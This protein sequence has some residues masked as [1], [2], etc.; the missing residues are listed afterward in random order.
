MRKK[1]RYPAWWNI[2][3]IRQPLLL[4]RV[5]VPIGKD[6]T[7]DGN[8]NV[9]ATAAICLERLA[10]NLARSFDFF[11]V[12]A[13]CRDDFLATN[14]GICRAYYEREEISERVKEYI[15]PQ[16]AADSADVVF[17]DAEGKTVL[18]DDIYQDDEGYFVYHDQI[19]DVENEKICLEPVLYRD[20]Y[21]DPDI[22][23]WKRCKRL[24]FVEYYSKK[25]FIEI[26]GAEAFAQIPQPDPERSVETKAAPK[27]QNIKVY[28]YWDEYENDVLWFAEDG[29]DFIT[30]KGYFEPQN[31]E[32]YALDGEEPKRGLYD[33][34]KFFPVPDPLIMNAATD[35]FY[36][37]PE[38]Y[39]LIEVFEDI[40]MIFSRMMALTRAIRARVLFDNNVDGLQEAL[41]E[42]SEGDA[43]GVPNLAQSLT[44]AGGTLDAVVQYIPVEKLINGLNQ[45]YIALDQRLMSVQRLTGTSDLLQGMSGDQSGK[46]LGERQIEEKYATNQIYE[47]QR[48]MSAF[49][50]DSYQLICEMALKN[51]KDASL[52]MYIIPATLQPEHR[53]RYRAALGML[54]E[55][56]KRFRIELETDSTIALNEQYD[57]QMRIELVNALTTALEKTANIA[58]VSPALVVTELHCLKYLVQGFRQGKM[59]QTEITQS[60]DNVIRQAAQ[61]PAP[62]N[63]DETGAR[64]KAQ[65]MQNANQIKV[66]EIQ[67][68]ERVEMAKLN[69]SA[70]IAMMGD[71]I[72]QFK[73][74]MQQGAKVQELQLA[75]ASL[76]ADVQKMQQELALKRDTLIIEMQQVAGE[77]ELE[78]F[79]IMLD[80]QL[81]PYEQQLAIYKLQLD[82]AELE[83]RKQDQSL[84]AQDQMFQAQNS[85]MD[86]ERQQARLDLD[87]AALAHEATK[88]PEM[89]PVTINMPEAAT[90]SEKLK[91]EMDDF[92]NLSKLIQENKQGPA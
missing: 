83:L 79:K 38:Y 7:Q 84:K 85:M 47:A 57:K 26:F 50:R 19:V 27:Q 90:K 75:Y 21:I 72:E 8:D 81:K 20:A 42:A 16:Q 46:T 29:P 70:Q 82:Q 12:M 1:A 6:M 65:E 78:Q 22:R 64:L 4:S 53:E 71:R 13:A 5:G 49:V 17:V 58:E 33:L 14:F 32:E 59:F 63:K 37:V 31:D 24:A 43:L 69:Q 40:H 60:I 39:Q 23:R 35:E 68:R 2:F 55:N 34:E 88:P 25:E 80:Q 3:K 36:P 77:K 76:D 86:N 41:N 74:Q 91:V 18:S 30:P 45:L 66:F 11:D 48:K 44:A 9:G 62:F 10:V 28:E 87:A 73:L 54:K 15:T 56:Q 52:D 89:P 92:G 61:A 67:S 51:F